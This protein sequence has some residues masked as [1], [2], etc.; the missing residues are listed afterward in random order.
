[1]SAPDIDRDGPELT[2]RNI[3]DSAKDAAGSTVTTEPVVEG[4]H[5]DGSVLVKAC[6]VAKSIDYTMR[7]AWAS[8][9]ILV[10]ILL[11]QGFSVYGF[12]LDSIVLTALVPSLSTAAALKVFS[13]IGN[14]MSQ[15][16]R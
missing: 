9:G 5:N 10:T 11:L 4:Q 15:N 16:G 1:M 12:Y 14:R 13:G 2:K 8:T 6:L 3:R 7:L